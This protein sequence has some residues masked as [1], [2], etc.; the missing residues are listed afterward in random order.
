MAKQAL[1]AF[2]VVVDIS[3]VFWFKSRNLARMSGE[4]GDLKELITSMVN[5]GW[6]VDDNGMFTVEKATDADVEEAMKLRTAQWESLKQLAANDSGKIVEL[7]V[8]EEIYLDT[9]GK[10]KEIQFVGLQGNRR[11]SAYLPAMVERRKKSTKEDPLPLT[12]EV[13]VIIREN[14]TPLERLQ[15][16]V[17]ENEDKTTGFAATSTL[18]KLLAAKRHFEL[19]ASQADLRKSFK[20]GM[21]QKLWGVVSLDAKFPSVRIIERMKLPQDNP[22]YIRVESAKF[23]DMPTLLTRADP[24]ALAEKNKKLAV[25]G[26]TPMAPLDEEAVKAYFA[27]PDLGGNKPKIMSRVNIESLRDQNPNLV[28]KATADAVLAN[29]TD[30]LS[31]FTMMA[32]AMN[33]VVGLGTDYPQVEHILLN[34]VAFGNGKRQAL[35]DR[36]IAE[37]EAFKADNA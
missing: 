20:D 30:G 23:S 2:A 24:A 35:F 29:K 26:Q 22:D 32:P 17:G 6:L 27:N 25:A 31:A 7:K 9:N 18:D 28:I 10:L 15:I 36:L 11:S 12:T 3:L 33:A 16:Q 34:L 1:K 19:G 5:K 13:A 4:Y 14:L 21:G 8:F 37:V